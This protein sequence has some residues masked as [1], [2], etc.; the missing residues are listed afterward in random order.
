MHKTKKEVV[1]RYEISSSA[2]EVPDTD[3][4]E[5]RVSIVEVVLEGGVYRHVGEA[6]L[7]GG[8]HPYGDSPDEAIHIGLRAGRAKLEGH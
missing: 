8:V 6:M 2:W 7:L 3:K 1:G 4:W 5:A